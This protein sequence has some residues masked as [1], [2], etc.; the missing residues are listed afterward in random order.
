MTGAPLRAAGGGVGDG[1]TRTGL[2]LALA[3]GLLLAVYLAVLRAMPPEV[4]WSPDEGIKFIV[5]ETVHWD[6][7][8]RYALPYRGAAVDPQFKFYPSNCY[9]NDLYP[10]PVGDGTIRFR[11]PIW[12]PLISRFFYSTFGLKGVYVLPLISGWLTAVL[13]GMLAARTHPRLGPFTVLLV[14]LGTPI[15]FFSMCFWEHTLATLCG[16]CAVALLSRSETQRAFP[17]VLMLLLLV[18]ALLLRVEMLAF[19]VSVLAVWGIDRLVA[20]RVTTTVATARGAQVR[21]GWHRQP[22]VAW[23]TAGCLALALLAG[24]TR[25]LA[26]R[27]LEVLAHAP[28]ALAASI[29]PGL[30]PSALRQVFI[31]GVDPQ[32]PPASQAW[33]WVT[34]I[35]AGVSLVAAFVSV[36]RWEA[37][38]IFPSL[39]VLLEFSVLTVL[40]TRAYLSRHG[41]LLVAPYLI[42]G[43]YV[44]PVA[45]RR[46]DT[47]LLRLAAV[48][49]LYAIA[50]FLAIF[51]T[52]VN[53]DGSY[54][55]GL[56]GGARYM[57]TLYP[58]GAVLSV[59]AVQHYRD[60]DRHPLAK[61][62]FTIL[63]AA[64]V[65]LAVQYQL[66][67]VEMLYN[68]R[69]LMSRWARALPEHEPVVTDSWWL[70][71]CLAPF[72]TTHEMYC[73]SEPAQLSAWLPAATAHGIAAFTLVSF[74]PLDGGT[75][76]PTAQLLIPESDQFIEGMYLNR[77]RLGIDAAGAGRQPALAGEPAR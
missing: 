10:A 2:A 14:G 30:L 70:G 54:Q 12:F 17:F 24:A 55:I 31:R 48:T 9:E 62:A 16:M 34:L 58:L 72:F 56:D 42:V 4:F 3:A 6:G 50:G 36:P 76:G 28:G 43:L 1:R 15:F 11:W 77:Y 41:V 39:V 67:G 73:V 23:L 53:W 59:V 26:P 20:L 37:G 74:S 13:A 49:V 71:A 68:S 64:M 45:W 51:I 38:L 52:R 35:A 57:L 22:R 65:I 27:H 44:L 21:R 63:V 7:G 47:P 75:L 5:L 40:S 61:S 46:R 8:F 60:S 19:A 25:F 69:Q 18:A 66:R 32:Q 33:E 29:R